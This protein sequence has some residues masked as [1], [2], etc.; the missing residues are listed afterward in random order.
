V[1]FPDDALSA[2]SAHTATA[3]DIAGPPDN[4]FGTLNDVAASVPVGSHGVLFTPW[5]N[6][7]R[8]PVDDHTIRGGFH[9]LSLSSTRADMVRA[10]FEGVALNS[11]WLLGAVE[12][13]CKRPF[14]T[15]AFVGGGANS[16]LWSQI[17]ADATGR[18][19][20]QIAD[21]VLA[22][23]RGAGLLTLL[24]LGHLRVA[25]ISGTVTVK[26]T[27][28]PDPAAGEVYAALLKEFVHLYEKTKAIH[29]RLNGRRLQ[30]LTSG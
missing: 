25:D 21:P 26:A 13:Y 2:T 1:L 23:V 11:A 20:R 5:L 16:D 30:Q 28:E 22:N 8:S 18:T 6:G 3:T 29:K 15:L 10:V 17:H 7:E 14:D 4:F 19:I 27:Y 24:A 12:K 9:N